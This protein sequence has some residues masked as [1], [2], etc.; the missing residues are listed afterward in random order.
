MH[1]NEDPGLGMADVFAATP[2]KQP[3][4][5]PS[6]FVMI[7]SLSESMEDRDIANCDFKSLELSRF[8]LCDFDEKSSE[9]GN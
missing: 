9:W 3:S 4:K 1:F 2:F 8:Q 6:E 5:I 7:D